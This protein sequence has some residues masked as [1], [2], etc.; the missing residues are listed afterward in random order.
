MPAYY[1]LDDTSV[2]ETDVLSL[3]QYADINVLDASYIKLRDLSLT[4][5]LPERA[6]REICAGSA[7]VRLQVSDL[8]VIPFNREG[9][10]PE[11]FSLRYGSRGDKF[12]PMMTLGVSIDF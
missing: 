9:I 12:R 8:F 7:S 3:Y 5:Y 11:A 10:D 6:C 4:Y 2:N 1:R